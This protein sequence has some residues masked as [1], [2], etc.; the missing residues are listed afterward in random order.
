MGVQ[1]KRGGARL[2]TPPNK[3]QMSP[4]IIEWR[5]FML[6]QTKKNL[7]GDYWKHNYLKNFIIGNVKKSG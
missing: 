1:N 4:R 2:P 6:V 3:G 5:R 7:N